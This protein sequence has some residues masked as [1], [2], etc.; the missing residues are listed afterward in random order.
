MGS[1][2]LVNVILEMVGPVNENFFPF[3]IIIPA[4]IAVALVIG[5]VYAFTKPGEKTS[6]AL[7]VILGSVYLYAGA[8]ILAGIGLMGP[9]AIEGAVSMWVI[10]GFLF[11]SLRK[12]SFVFSLPAEWDLKILSLYFIVHGLVLY[13]IVELLF[14]YGWPTMVFIGAECPTTILLIGLLIGSIRKVN[15]VVATFLFLFAAIWGSYV[16]FNGFLPDV[17]YGLAG[18]A[19][20]AMVVKYKFIP[21]YAKRQA[22]R[23]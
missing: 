21:R 14:G 8:Q 20:L 2:N 23:G 13:P 18:I 11:Y 22:V 17:F 19:G 10:G 15:T 5:I 9:V 3:S 7:K 4:A 1:G 12:G 6:A 16:G